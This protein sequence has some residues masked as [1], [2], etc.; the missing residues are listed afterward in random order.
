MA[1]PPEGGGG[2]GLLCKAGVMALRNSGRTHHRAGAFVPRL[3]A[4]EDRCCPSVSA[5]VTGTTLSIVG[6]NLANVVTITDDGQ[7]HVSATIT[8]P[9][10]GD[11]QNASGANINQ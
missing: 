9:K 10:T 6:D 7:G 1:D 3:E 11:T 2:R 4:L 8:S 5:T